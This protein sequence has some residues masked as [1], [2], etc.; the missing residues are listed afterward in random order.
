MHVDTAD[1]VADELSELSCVEVARPFA[2]LPGYWDSEEEKA[3]ETVGEDDGW[4]VEFTTARDGGGD[5]IPYTVLRVCVEND[6]HVRWNEDDGIWEAW[7]RDR[8]LEE[9]VTEAVSALE[10]IVDEAA[11]QRRSVSNETVEEAMTRVEA[12]A[13]HDPDLEEGVERVVEELDQIEA[14]ASSHSA[15]VDH[16]AVQEVLDTFEGELV[17]AGHL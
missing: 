13:R 4:R 8:D 16:T 9:L 11:D 12:V 1:A 7:S 17:E 3:S 10:R 14:I 2:A 6:L 15:W 5:Q